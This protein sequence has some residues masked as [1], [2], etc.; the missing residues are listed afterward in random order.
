MN[1]ILN[2]YNSKQCICLHHKITCPLPQILVWYNPRRLPAMH[3]IKA[4]IECSEALLHQVPCNFGVLLQ[5][6]YHMPT[7]VGEPALVDFIHDGTGAPLPPLRLYMAAPR[8]RIRSVRLGPLL[9]FLLVPL[10][11]SGTDLSLLP[12]DSPSE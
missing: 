3:R 5:Y 9:L 2:L 7:A 12:S 1:F 8:P 11:Y 6:A 4:Q 10:I